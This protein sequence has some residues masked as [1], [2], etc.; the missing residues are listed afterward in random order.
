VKL[1]LIGYGIHARRVHSHLLSYHCFTIDIYARSLRERPS[2]AFNKLY[3]SLKELLQHPAYDACFILTSDPS[4]ESVL[5]F[6]LEHRLAR[7]LYIEKPALNCEYLLSSA[8]ASSFDFIKIGYNLR[9]DYNY[10]FFK[11]IIHTVNHTSL[12]LSIRNTHNGITT[13]TNT[14]NW[15]VFDKYQILYTSASHFINLLYYLLPSVPPLTAS[16]ISYSSSSIYDTVLIKSISSSEYPSI[17]IFVSWALAPSKLTNLST[18]D[19]YLSFSGSSPVSLSCTSENIDCLNYPSFYPYF[20]QNYQ[21]D[22]LYLSL[23]H[24][25]LR[26]LSNRT[27][28]YCLADFTPTLTTIKSLI[29]GI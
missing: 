15:R 6:V 2:L 11:R 29:Y 21:S 27:F 14:N 8:S 5:G 12:S 16:F 1:L 4:H 19:I 13:M 25:I 24:F 26:V 3:S 28:K 10:N 22:S 9:H 17:R 18:N 23:R 7:C 20:F